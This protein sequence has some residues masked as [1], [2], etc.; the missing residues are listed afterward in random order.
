MFCAFSTRVKRLL[1][2]CVVKRYMSISPSATVSQRKVVQI[3]WCTEPS[4]S[5]STISLHL[6][7]RINCLIFCCDASL[8]TLLYAFGL[9]SPWWILKNNSSYRWNIE[10]GMYVKY[11]CVMRWSPVYLSVRASLL[12]S[13]PAKHIS[14]NDALDSFFVHVSFIESSMVSSIDRVCRQ[15]VIS[16]LQVIGYCD[17][18][19]VFSAEYLSGSNHFSRHR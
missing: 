8:E 9:W 2:D 10:N 18:R 5:K 13:S 14:S 1:L 7:S 6:A 19:E 17:F 12:D 11:I 15:L 16:I 4:R 3:A